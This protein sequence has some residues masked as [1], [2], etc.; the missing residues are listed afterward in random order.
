M[1]REWLNHPVTAHCI[2]FGGSLAL[3]ISIALVHSSVGAQP[4]ELQARG[5]TSAP[6]AT[7]AQTQVPATRREA[8]AEQRDGKRAK[9][10]AMTLGLQVQPQGNQ[11]LQV[12]KLEEN[13]I[14][15]KAGLQANDHILSVDGRQF[16]SGRQLD[17]YLA[18]QGGRRVPLVIDRNGQRSTVYVTPNPIAGDT[19]WLGVYLEESDAASQGARI[20]QVYPSGPAARAGLQAGD[21]ITQIDDQKVEGPADVITIVQESEPQAKTQFSIIRNE[22]EMNIPVVLGSREHFV[23]PNNPYGQYGNGNGHGDH[24]Q[25]APPQGAGQDFEDVPPH[26]M[27]L[28]HDRRLAEQHQR[29]EQEIQALREEI[30]QL[31][32]ELKKK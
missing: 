8:K 19:A 12:S 25:F 24:S 31:R 3:G 11:G 32:E 6:V 30:H 28:E 9:R 20:T 16:T 17:A 26:A 7:N 5:K 13:S 27:Q 18:S 23:P 22:Q 1:N 14:A 15:A 2:I 29:I 21:T 10:R 4:S